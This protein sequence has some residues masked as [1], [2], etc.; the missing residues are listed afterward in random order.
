MGS[1]YQEMSHTGKLKLEGAERDGKPSKR[2][3]ETHG[4]PIGGEGE[5]GG[6]GQN[7]RGHG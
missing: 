5:E 4:E 7:K 1:H 2:K 3:P 6:G